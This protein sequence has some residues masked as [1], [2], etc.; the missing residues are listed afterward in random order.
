MG[1]LPAMGQS[2]RIDPLTWSRISHR[3]RTAAAAEPGKLT[4]LL[5]WP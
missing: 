4:A 1:G 5:L 3:A 2:R